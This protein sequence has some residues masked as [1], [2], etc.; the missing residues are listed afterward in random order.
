MCL[1]TIRLLHFTLNG[2]KLR[3]SAAPV[4]FYN[5]SSSIVIISSPHLKILHGN[6]CV[7]PELEAN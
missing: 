3:R 1:S 5:L 4:T 7:Q 6:L 2:L